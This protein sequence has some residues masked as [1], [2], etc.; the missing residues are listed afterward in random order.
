MNIEGEKV[1]D[2]FACCRN[3]SNKLHHVNS[4]VYALKEFLGAVKGID[5]VYK[6]NP[7]IKKAIDNIEH[8]TRYVYDGEEN[9]PFVSDVLYATRAALQE[10]NEW[11]NWS[12]YT[13]FSKEEKQ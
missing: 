5:E 12:D 2:L 6:Q 10:A 7:L 3:L 4:Q 13:G 1:R 9:F 11:R 8:Y